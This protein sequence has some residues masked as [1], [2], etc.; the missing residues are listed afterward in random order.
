AGAPLDATPIFISA[1][2][3]KSQ[4]KPVENMHAGKGTVRYRRALPPEVFYTNWSYVDHIVI[5]PG[6][7]MGKKRHP[8]VEELYYVIDGAGT[9]HVNDESAPIR[10]DQGLA[11]L[12]NDVHSL[13]NNGSG[14]L[15][16]MVIG[17]AVEK[18][19]LDTVNVK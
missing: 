12:L 3:D 17:V 15:E 7:S 10:K 8:G 2:F 9:M 16:L 18:W 19:V 1:R 11:V 6:A 4:L 5:P 13:E 14:D